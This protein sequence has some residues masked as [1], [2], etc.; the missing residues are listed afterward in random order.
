MDS[1]FMAVIMT[2]STIGA[3]HAQFGTNIEHKH[4]YTLH[5]KLL[6]ISQQL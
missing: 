3:R 1:G 2:L 6:L 4:T 5:I